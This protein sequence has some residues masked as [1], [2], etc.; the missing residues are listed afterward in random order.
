MPADVV[1]DIT[2]HEGTAASATRCA[3]VTLAV[4]S[5]AG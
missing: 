1:H 4:A 5:G 3:G 2:A